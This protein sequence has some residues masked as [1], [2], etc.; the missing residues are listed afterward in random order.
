MRVTISINGSFRQLGRKELFFRLKKLDRHIFSFF[1]YLFYKH[2]VVLKTRGTFWRCL[3]KLARKKPIAILPFLLNCGF[4]D[5]LNE[6]RQLVR[7]QLQ[8]HTRII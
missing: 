8:S 5:D 1:I 6:H 4:F 7:Q 3:F 2:G